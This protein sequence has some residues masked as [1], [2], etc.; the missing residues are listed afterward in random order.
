MEALYDRKGNIH[1]WLDVDLGNILDLNGRHVAFLADG[2]VYDW[3]GRHIGWWN[4]GCVRDA[5]NAIA[6]FTTEALDIGVLRP[7][8]HVRPV[9]PIEA[10][11]PVR[12]VERVEPVK[13]VGR[14]IWSN[15]P[16]F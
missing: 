1:A 15:Q 13:P 2:S 5:A 6:Y 9:Q 12:P 16:P 10:V 4:D 3:K 8:K 11:A 14:A 7:V